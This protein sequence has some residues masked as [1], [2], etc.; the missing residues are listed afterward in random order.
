M[1]RLLPLVDSGVVGELLKSHLQL[2]MPTY[3]AE[4]DEV[5]GFQR[6]YTSRPKS[7]E[8]IPAFDLSD[9]PQMP[10]IKIVTTGPSEEPKKDGE[11]RVRATYEN[12]VVAIV[13][14]TDSESTKAL[15]DRYEAAIVGAVMH[16]R[17]LGSPLVRG[18]EYG[19][20]N[21]FDLPADERRTKQA[22]SCRFYIEYETAVNWKEGPSEPIVDPDPYQEPPEDPTQ[23]IPDFGIVRDPD[24]DPPY[25]PITLTK[26]EV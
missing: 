4:M 13:E 10:A 7:W 25:T 15:R 17:S 19:G 26:E 8:I 14:S 5:K 21:G 6:G 9:M 1:S 2:W 16:K 20:A 3:L 23:P 12:N 11:G 24:S 22:V 18:T